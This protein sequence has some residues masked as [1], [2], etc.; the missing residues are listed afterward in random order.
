MPGTCVLSNGSQVHR[1]PPVH[2]SASRRPEPDAV[3]DGSDG[4]W[5]RRI[6]AARLDAGQHGVCRL[7]GDV[8]EV[9][10]QLQRR[11]AVRRGRGHERLDHYQP[12]T[13]SRLALANITEMAPPIEW[14]TRTTGSGTTVRTRASTSATKSSP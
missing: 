11:I 9:R 2:G 4:V 1:T 6:A 8:I 10:C 5:W 3:S 7:G 12:R 13:S 14:P